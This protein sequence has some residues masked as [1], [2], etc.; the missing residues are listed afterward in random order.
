M[1]NRFSRLKIKVMVLGLTFIKVDHCK[2]IGSLLL[3]QKNKVWVN[4]MFLI[5][6]KVINLNSYNGTNESP[7][8]ATHSKS[9]NFHN[10]FV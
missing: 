9:S 8:A 4:Y 7:A 6:L 5:E 1:Y 3:P 10:H 2:E